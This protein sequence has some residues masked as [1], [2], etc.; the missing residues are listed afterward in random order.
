LDDSPKIKTGP[1]WKRE[2][3]LHFLVRGVFPARIAKLL[4]LQTIRM[5]LL[6]F[7]R[8]VVAVLTVPA[9][10]RNDFPHDLV[11]FSESF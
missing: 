3:L 10:Q 6:V 9:L 4:R 8:R 2:A 11:P 5:L 1:A 7:C